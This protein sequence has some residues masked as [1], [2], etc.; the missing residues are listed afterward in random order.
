MFDFAQGRR[1]VDA[2][3]RGA[4]RFKR[5]KKQGFRF[6]VGGYAGY[7]LGSR[8]KFVF[9]DG[10]NK[11]K[12]IN[13]NNFYLSNFR[14]GIRAQMGYKGVDFFANY[15]LNKVFAQDKGP[16]LNAISFGIIF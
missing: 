5:S 1:K 9:K 11:E 7:R 15:D 4:F 10:G 13:R 16:D 6:G 3:E 2:I 12:D 8:S 14:Y